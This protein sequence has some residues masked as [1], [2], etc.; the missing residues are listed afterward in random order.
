EL[1][2][3]NIR[4]DWRHIR[5]IMSAQTLVTTRMKLENKDCLII[6]QPARANQQAAVIYNTLNFKHANPSIRKKAVVPHK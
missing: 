2:K 6:R 4:Y 5:N 1:K 3:K